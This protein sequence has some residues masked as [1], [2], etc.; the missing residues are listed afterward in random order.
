[1]VSSRPSLAEQ[2]HFGLKCRLG[3]ANVQIS[4]GNAVP[5][6]NHIS[7]N[8][9]RRFKESQTLVDYFHLGAYSR[10]ALLHLIG[11][12][13][14][15]YLGKNPNE[16]LLTFR[17]QGSITSCHLYPPSYLLRDLGWILEYAPFAGQA[18]LNCSHG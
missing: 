1:M 3:N 16:A 8:P 17:R 10:K 5:D 9:S 15:E 11:L 6:D 4:S 2:N 12:M 18:A 14:V 7:D 13:S